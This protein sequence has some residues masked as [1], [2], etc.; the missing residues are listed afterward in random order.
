MQ[1]VSQIQ[2]APDLEQGVHLMSLLTA[3]GGTRLSLEVP[4]KPNYSMTVIETQLAHR[5]FS[6][7]SST[8]SEHIDSS[9]TV[10]SSF[11]TY[12]LVLYFPINK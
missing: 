12:S 2:H 1:Q 11:M 4:S 3:Q 9:L 6:Q 8:S 10:V 5:G 7:V